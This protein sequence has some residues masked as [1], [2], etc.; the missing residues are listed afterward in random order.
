MDG[1]WIGRTLLQPCRVWRRLWPR[2]PLP[3]QWRI[4]PDTQGTAHR[5]AHSI[6]VTWHCPVSNCPVVLGVIFSFALIEKF[7]LR[8]KTIG[9]EYLRFFTTFQANFCAVFLPQWIRNIT[10][11]ANIAW[12]ADRKVRNRIFKHVSSSNGI[13]GQFLGCYLFRKVLLN[14]HHGHRAA[15]LENEGESELTSRQLSVEE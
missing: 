13:L 14:C 1:S 4:R 7:N 15:S 6:A 5:W 10:I 2:Q 12:K 9:A 11:V 3:S 8:Y